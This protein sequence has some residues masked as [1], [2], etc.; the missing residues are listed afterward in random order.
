[1]LRFMGSHRVGCDLATELF[2]WEKN[3]KKNG[4]Y[5]CIYESVIHVYIYVST[6][7]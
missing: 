1:M 3:L 6:H 4:I 7:V 5:I 2:I